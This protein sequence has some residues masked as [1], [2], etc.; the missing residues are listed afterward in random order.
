MAQTRIEKLYALLDQKKL[1]VALV[2]L[3]SL[4]YY[5]TGF[6]TNPHERFVALVCP[7][8]DSPFLFVPALD[9]EK[10]ERVSSVSTVIAHTDSQNPFE[11]LKRHLPTGITRIGIQADHL[12]VNRYQALLEAT[13]ASHTVDLEQELAHIRVVKSQSEIVIVKRAVLC[14][15]EAIAQTLPLIKPGVTENEIV[16][17][18][19]LRM[20]R[21]GAS[22]PS[23]DTMVL[24][25]ENT[26]LPHGVPGTNKVQE[27]QLLLIDAGVFVDGYA[28][29]I[30]RTFAVGE[31]SEKCKDIYETVLQANRSAIQAARPGIT[32]ASLD[33]AARSVIESKGYGEYFSHR[34]GHGFGLDIHEYPSIHGSNPDP[35][36]EGMLI[37]IE[38]GIY[39]RGIGGVRIEDDVYITADGAEV[40]T[41]FPKELTVIGV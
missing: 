31:V 28:S 23:F 33:Q 7:K 22:G 30:T 21:L 8:G 2:T 1:D 25:G 24:T 10:A 6:H 34:T 29:D 9:C 19:E 15:E 39:I 26:G 32:L 37:T 4:I 36:R 18:L 13:G 20:K 41:S 16:S 27:G 38:P 11:V 3:P 14:I 17:E 12:N 5:F 35:V 40:L